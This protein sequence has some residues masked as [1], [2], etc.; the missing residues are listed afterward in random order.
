MAFQ[1]NSLAPSM[2]VAQNLYPGEEKFFN[3]LRGHYIAAR[4]LLASLNFNVGPWI[5][6][7]TLGTAKKQMVEIAPAVRHDAR[8]IVFDEPTASLAPEERRHFFALV[9]RLEERG[10]SIIFVSHALEEAQELSHRITVTR[11]GE[12]VAT[13]LA[14]I[15]DRDRIIRAMAGRSLSDRL[16]ERRGGVGR[17][18][19]PEGFSETMSIAE[20]LCVGSLAAAKK[21]GFV[22][23]LGQMQ[24]LAAKWSRQLAVKAVDS[25][26]RV[27]ELSGGNRQKAAIA[28]SSARK[29][30]LIIFDE[31]TRG[32]DVG[33]IAE[34]H[35][36]IRRLAEDGSAVIA[37]STYPPEAL[38]L[39]DPILVSQRGRIVEEFR[40]S[41][42]T[43]ER[44]M[45]AAVR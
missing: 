16:Y 18:R 42:A 32:V 33:A 2:T 36:R 21:G 4:R 17:T 45:F 29:P 34:I 35:E 5:P 44:I 19:K 20:N 30:N 31:P 7:A 22:V 12:R 14:S 24:A 37:I 39:S 10:V 38:N 13:D 6:I 28:K 26:A 25:N 9:G 8:V 11:D 43:E 15:F 3:R 40:P 23:N 41:E 27:I 1:E